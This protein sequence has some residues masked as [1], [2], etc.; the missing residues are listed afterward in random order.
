[1]A[2]PAPRRD[3]AWLL[4]LAGWLFAT[5]S[6]GAW[7]RAG[8]PERRL[9]PQSVDLQRSSARELRRLP[10]IGAVRANR[11]VDLRWERGGA[12]FELTEVE[13]IG[14]LT[15]ARVLEALERN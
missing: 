1:M 7:T 9:P 4:F 3:P 5:L 15:E 12:E 11:V 10:G 8:R 14:P 2:R 13:G 6:L